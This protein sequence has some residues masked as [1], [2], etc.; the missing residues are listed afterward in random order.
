MMAMMPAFAT[1]DAASITSEMT[2]SAERLAHG[3]DRMIKDGANV[4]ATTGSFG[5]F[6][7]LLPNE[8][9]AIAR[10]AS[11]TN[12]QRVPLF[13]GAT[14]LNSREVVQKM[15]VISETKA[16]GALIGVPFY[17]PSSPANVVNFYR[18]IAELFPKLAIMIYHNPPL[19]NVRLPVPVMEQLA[20]IPNV[21]AMKDSHRQPGEFL[22]MV[23]V[24]H[25][26][27]RVF[28]NQLQFSAYAPLG[29]AGF[30]SIEAWMGPWPQLALRDAVARG[31]FSTANRI[32]TELVIAGGGEKDPGWRETAAK[33]AVRYA[34]YVDPGPLRPPFIEVP[35]D[36]DK[37]QQ[38][39]AERWKKLCEEYR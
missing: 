22:R 26:K 4:V 39:R 25:S 28:V 21:I 13:I 38:V 24:T 8:F 16:D 23:D 30:W 27:V 34:G 6:H 29:A 36:V 32:T 12:R 33:V 35:P 18:G 11:E 1:D 3:L 17:F 15:K 31:D 19:H 20:K 14:A 10:A 5:E 2:V 7:T 9:A 37:A